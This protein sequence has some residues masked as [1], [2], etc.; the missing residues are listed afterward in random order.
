MFWLAILGVAVN[1]MAAY[2][3]SQGKTLNERVLN[4]HLIAGVLGWFTVLS[5]WNSPA[6]SVATVSPLKTLNGVVF[7]RMIQ[8][9]LR[10]IN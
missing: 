3:L 2:K 7:E 6:R 4:W 10:I 8:W 9:L 5:K 1:G